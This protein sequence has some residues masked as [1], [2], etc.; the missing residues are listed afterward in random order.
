[1][2]TTVEVP[3][4]LLVEAKRLAFELSDA[5]DYATTIR[6]YRQIVIFDYW[7]TKCE[8]EQTETAV[9]ARKFIYDATAAQKLG[10]FEEAREVYRRRSLE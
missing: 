6:R 5:Q 3:D 2:K 4:T 9:S 1:M 8:V 10:Q 7:E